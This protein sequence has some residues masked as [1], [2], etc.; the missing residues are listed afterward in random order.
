[1][2][3]GQ[4]KATKEDK[5]G[6]FKVVTQGPAKET[7]LLDFS[8]K[9]VGSLSARK[10]EKLCE[11]IRKNTPH[12]KRLVL[13]RCK[14]NDK[15]LKSCL[16]EIGKLKAL[17]QLV[18]SDNDIS[19]GSCIILEKAIRGLK[20]SVFSR[21]WPNLERLDYEGNK[22]ITARGKLL[23]D[24]AVM[25]NRALISTWLQNIAESSG[26]Q[27]AALHHDEE[28]T[29]SAAPTATIAVGNPASAAPIKNQGAA[30]VN[31][32]ESRKQLLNVLGKAAVENKEHNECNDITADGHSKS[33]QAPCLS[34]QHSSDSLSEYWGSGS[35]INELPAVKLCPQCH[36]SN[37]PDTVQCARCEEIFVG[38]KE[39]DML[40]VPISHRLYFA[41]KTKTVTKLTSWPALPPQPPP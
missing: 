7:G 36:A 22:K 17:E 28:A 18:L 10:F 32:E 34:K 2:G 27:T 19:D 39:A 14:L 21:C 37:K 41:P 38:T 23:L 16:P 33:V 8:G 6:I 20:T 9:P 31:L 40:F 29:L 35:E 3:S 11:G 5:E 30:E 4:T 24:Q 26:R 1:M 15:A 12:I 25:S 13:R